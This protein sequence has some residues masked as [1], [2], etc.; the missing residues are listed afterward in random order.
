MSVVLL[1]LCFHFWSLLCVL[2]NNINTDVGDV[3]DHNY[4]KGIAKQN[5]E[6]S[7]DDW[8]VVDNNNLPPSCSL[9]YT[10]S[11]LNLAAQ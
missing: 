1:S 9:F 7:K 3:F 6:D 11:Y 5:N 4:M 2:L 8:G 10:S